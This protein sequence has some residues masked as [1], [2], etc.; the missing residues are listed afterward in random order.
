MI[1]IILFI[2]TVLIFTAILTPITYFVDPMFSLTYNL[3]INIIVSAIVLGGFIIHSS[4]VEIQ[5]IEHMRSDGL[6]EE[7]IK[8]IM[9]V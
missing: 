5:T 7:D 9:E 2:L 6:S 3:I 1:K 4:I 8:K